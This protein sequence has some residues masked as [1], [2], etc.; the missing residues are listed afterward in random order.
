MN[1][2][3]IIERILSLFHC[4][5]IHMAFM[6]DDKVTCMFKIS[7]ENAFMIESFQVWLKND[8]ASDVDK[9]MCHY[10]NKMVIKLLYNDSKMTINH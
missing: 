3:V 1:D 8:Y 4:K 5:F 6:I 7:F 10:I 2:N 9:M